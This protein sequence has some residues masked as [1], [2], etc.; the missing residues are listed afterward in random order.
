[1]IFFQT[2]YK[3][4]PATLEQFIALQEKVD[5]LSKQVQDFKNR[6]NKREIDNSKPFN[7]Y[8]II[9]VNN[10]IIRYLS[11]TAAL[12]PTIL[13]NEIILWNDTTNNKF[14]LKANFN[15]TSKKVEL[16]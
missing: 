10:L 3:D 5:E 13:S 16:L 14:Y 7:F 2:I 1:M 4:M 8:N 6:L 11:T 12:E 9:R 15:G